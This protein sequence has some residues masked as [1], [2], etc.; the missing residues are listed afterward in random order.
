MNARHLA[1]I[2]FQ[3]PKYG[4]R[5]PATLI[6]RPV[7]SRCKREVTVHAFTV[8]DGSRIETH[9]CP[10]HGDVPSMQ[11]HIVTVLPEIAA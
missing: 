10:V 11:S 3:A 6:R 8:K 5:D 1:A 4:Y 2:E 7:C 9:H